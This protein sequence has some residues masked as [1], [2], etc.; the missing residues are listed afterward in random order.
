[1]LVVFSH[2]SR[3]HLLAASFSPFFPKKSILVS[4]SPTGSTSK[5]GAT[6]RR[7]GKG[8]RKEMVFSCVCKQTQ[9]SRWDRQHNFARM[10][11]VPHETIKDRATSVSMIARGNAL[12]VSAV[13]R[14]RVAR[15][16][17]MLDVLRKPMRKGTRDGS[18]Y[19]IGGGGLDLSLAV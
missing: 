15:L 4:M 12:V 7:R 18:R 6:S 13:H 14:A 11:N 8:S 17:T 9:R 3:E 1:M 5:S 10:R 19:G 2:R 16:G